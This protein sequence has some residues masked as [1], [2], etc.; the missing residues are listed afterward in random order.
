[1]LLRALLAIFAFAHAS[2]FAFAHE[3]CG[4]KFTQERSGVMT[5]PPSQ[6]HN[7]TIENYIH[8]KW[9][10]EMAPG[11]KIAVVLKEI[12]LDVNDSLVITEYLNGHSTAEL[13]N[14]TF[15]E[16]KPGSVIFS[17]YNRLKVELFAAKRDYVVFD[18]FFEDTHCGGL[19]TEPQ[20][21]IVV[22]LSLHLSSSFQNC[23][24]KLNTGSSKII[25]LS[26]SQFS[27]PPGSCIFQNLAIMEGDNDDQQILGDFC[28]ENPPAGSI[29]SSQN[30]ITIDFTK[31]PSFTS[32]LTPQIPRIVMNYEFVDRCSS[33]M[34]GLF[35]SISV[36]L[37]YATFQTSTQ[38]CQWEVEVPPIHSISLRFL[39]YANGPS[40]P[41]Q[42]QEL[43]IYDGLNINETRLL[44]S[45]AN[46]M[47]PPMEL[48]TETNGLRIVRR[49]VRDNYRSNGISFQAVYQA[50][51]NLDTS[52]EDCIYIGERRFFRCS[53]GHFI[54]CEWKCDGIA[55]CEDAIDEAECSD[56]QVEGFSLTNHGNDNT[57]SF[58]RG[59]LLVLL[60]TVFVLFVCLFVLSM[61][62]VLHERL[63]HSYQDKNSP[64][65]P[66]YEIPRLPA[67]R[68]RDAATETSSP[69]QH[70]QETQAI[71]NHVE[72]TSIQYVNQKTD[73][74]TQEGHNKPNAEVCA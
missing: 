65:L 20:G 39:K 52:T 45:S 19:L 49:T 37:H 72:E 42:S 1:M 25:K 30:A 53:N 23:S 43:A 40:I 33:K 3:N 70:N 73:V 5:L 54:D 22:P 8:C 68:E 31:Q 13:S 47:F 35:G 24:W 69:S 56:G 67:Y 46:G 18:A 6:Q 12:S 16:L 60:L 28:D 11:H 17:Q 15:F 48:A 32:D 14:I 58:I 27:L 36:P 29:V 9:T 74:A 55:D 2:N 61:D 41:G 26:F 66:A 38:N 21:Q 44:W 10:I 50:Q 64:K 4:Y 7:K 34:S 59:T 51:I 57:F 62:R 71:Y 63:Q